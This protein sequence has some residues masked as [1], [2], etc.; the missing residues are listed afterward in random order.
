MPKPTRC[1]E[2]KWEYPE[3]LLN[4]MFVNGGHTPPICG[5]CALEISNRTH[6]ISRKKFDGPIAEHM[7]QLAIRWRKRN[8]KRAPVDVETIN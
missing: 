4:S 5:Q 2:C 6:G 8:P 1:P 3:N 7:R